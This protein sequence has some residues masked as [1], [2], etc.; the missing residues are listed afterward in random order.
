VCVV[1][2]H[3]GSSARGSLLAPAFAA[4]L[5]AGNH[6]ALSLFLVDTEAFAGQGALDASLCAV[7]RWARA[8]GA[9]RAAVVGGASRRRRDVEDALLARSD[10]R[11][12]RAAAEWGGSGPWG[13]G[14]IDA[15]GRGKGAWARGYVA[16]DA[17]MNRLV[18]C[19]GRVRRACAWPASHGAPAQEAPG[20]GEAGWEEEEEEEEADPCAGSDAAAAAA[21]A[22]GGAAAAAVEA[23]ARGAA[24]AEAAGGA[25][26]GAAARGAASEAAGTSIGGAETSPS[27]AEASTSGAETSPGGAKTS[28]GGVETSP[29]TSPGGAETSSPGTSPVGAETSP[30]TSPV[31]APTSPGGASPETSPVGRPVLPLPVQPG[32]V[33]RA[34]GY[35]DADAGA[36]PC[37]YV[38]VTNTDNLYAEAFL[39]LVLSRG[40][41][42]LWPARGA[43]ALHDASAPRAGRDAVGVFY[44]THY[45]ERGGRGRSHGARLVHLP[46]DGSAAGQSVDLGAFVWSARALRDANA[47]FLVGAVRGAVA[48]ALGG[49]G[50]AGLAAIWP[51]VGARDH[52]LAHMVNSAVIAPRRRQQLLLQQQRLQQQQADV[53]AIVSAAAAD[54]LAPAPAPALHSPLPE[55][56]LLD[57]VEILPEILFWHQ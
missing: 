48:A 23:A 35:S 17:V 3:D 16:T 42:P 57:P 26:V 1:A 44:V 4:S 27:G 54:G 12:P 15:S 51:T 29:G 30:G 9:A 53:A 56:E 31:G 6:S 2:R 32:A 10:W 11:A 36:P 33:R 45:A 37:D 22:A 50:G 20:R 39:P 25:A 40:V 41:Q 13:D 49:D 24:A 52:S 38:L 46:A 28:P 47:T 34:R 55:S 7:A 14:P 19:G 8:A 21:E 43:A 5:L 18:R